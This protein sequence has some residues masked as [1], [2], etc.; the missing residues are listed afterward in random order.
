MDSTEA[1]KL[2]ITFM[3]AALKEAK[4]YTDT[5]IAAIINGLQYRGAVNYYDDLANVAKKIGFV[6]TVMYKG[7]SGTD[8]D[9]TEY[10]WGEYES[11]AQWIP[12]GPDI[13][14]KAD[15]VANATTGH[16]AGLDSNGNLIDSGKSPSDF[17]T[18]ED[19]GVAGGIAGLDLS[20]CVPASQLP[21]LCEISNMQF[22]LNTENI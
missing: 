19:R 21:I 22:T 12:L 14:A 7:S 1:K 5:S 6:Y 20:G 16:L 4:S 17:Y 15:K 2:I 9:G 11:V 8:P 18:A 10:V 3:Q 13:S